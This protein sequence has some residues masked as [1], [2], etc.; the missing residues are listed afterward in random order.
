MTDLSDLRQNA[1]PDFLRL[2][3]QLDGQNSTA[4]KFQGEDSPLAKARGFVE[5]KYHA[6]RTG[7][8]HS[9]KEARYA[10]EL[11]LRQQAGEISF[12]LEQVPLQLVETIYRIDFVVFRAVTGDGIFDVDWVEVKGRDLP[13]GRLKRK[14][15]EAKYHIKI[16]VV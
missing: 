7:H 1:S 14:Q 2:N 3:P 6:Q 13:L 10:N 9:K 15:A 5:N 16:E 11:Y 8:Y 12:W 4:S